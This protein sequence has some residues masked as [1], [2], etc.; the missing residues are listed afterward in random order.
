MLRHHTN[1]NAARVAGPYL[2]AIVIFLLGFI[3]GKFSNLPSYNKQANEGQRGAVAETSLQETRRPHEVRNVDQKRQQEQREKRNPLP[4]PEPPKL[5]PA[6]VGKEKT[7]HSPEI[8]K[9]REGPQQ[10]RVA[11]LK[12]FE[13]VERNQVGYASMGIP[14][15]QYCTVY[16][17][18]QEEKDGSLRVNGSRIEDLG[19]Q[20]RGTLPR[21]WSQGTSVQ[22]VI[23]GDLV[24][25]E[26]RYINMRTED[27][28]VSE[29]KSVLAEI[30]SLAHTLE[31]A[32][33]PTK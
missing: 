26:V 25:G 7:P 12:I 4:E 29:S 16:L 1:N 23:S 19:S 3:S 8:K 9:I 22:A 17:A 31:L 14:V 28:I 18:I 10:A 5:H 30:A 24:E 11:L 33:L 13:G 2:I 15:T 27:S 6:L 21:P 32:K 20:S